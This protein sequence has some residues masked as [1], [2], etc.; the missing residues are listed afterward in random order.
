MVFK[1]S[2]ALALVGA[3]CLTFGGRAYS[4]PATPS[5]AARPG[6]HKSYESFQGD[7]QYCQTSAKQTIGY[8]SPG[9]AANDVQARYDTVYAQCMTAKGNWIPPPSPYFLGVGY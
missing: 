8:Q 6:P 7:D 1:E 4:G 2:V 3:F 9:Q 5:F